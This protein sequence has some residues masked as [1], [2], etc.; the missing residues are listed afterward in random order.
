MM[1]TLCPALHQ[2]PHESS[3]I[4]REIQRFSAISIYFCFCFVQFFCLVVFF[5][6]HISYFLTKIIAGIWLFSLSL[7]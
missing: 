5:L 6:L 2:R 4:Y 1:F 3:R 7:P